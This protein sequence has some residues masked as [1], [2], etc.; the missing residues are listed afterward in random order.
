[1]ILIPPEVPNDAIVKADQW[2]ALFEACR[3]MYRYRP[4]TCVF[5]SCLPYAVT[6]ATA[7]A[8][9]CGTNIY[10][11][12]GAYN[13][14]GQQQYYTMAA[15]LD[16]TTSGGSSGWLTYCYGYR[17]ITAGSQLPVGYNSNYSNGAI[18]YSWSGSTAFNT[19]RHVASMT[20][21]EGKWVDTDGY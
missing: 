5:A 4:S 2:A 21:F 15:S 18:P 1:M 3:A 13:V 16:E 8:V 12:H 17:Y 14:T 19:A 9:Q 7:G 20:A 10:F 6:T 11:G